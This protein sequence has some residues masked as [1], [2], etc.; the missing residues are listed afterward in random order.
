MARMP[1]CAARC[2]NCKTAFECSNGSSPTAESKPRPKS[3]PCVN[4]TRSL[5]RTRPDEERRI[6][7]GDDRCDRD[8]RLDHQGEDPRLLS[9]SQDGWADRQSGT[10]GEPS[11][12]R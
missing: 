3:K 9:R 5:K 1:G 11:P 12:A 2:S 8:D 7:G 10:A 6:D 4:A